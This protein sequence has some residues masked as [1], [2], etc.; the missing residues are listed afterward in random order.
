MEEMRRDKAVLFDVDDTLY[1]Q[2]VPFMESYDQYFG[3]NALISAETIYPVTRR[4]SDQMFSSAMAGKITMDELYIYRVRK[5][6]A[7]FG[8]GITDEEALAFQRLYEIRQ[9]YIRMSPLMEEILSWCSGKVRVGIITNGPSGRQ[10]EKVRSLG[11]ERWIPHEN[12]FVSEDVGAEKPDRKIFDYARRSMGLE[13]AES[14]FVGDAYPLDIEGALNA[15][16]NAVWFRRRNRWKPEPSERM[17]ISGEP[18][19]E[20]DGERKEKRFGAR[21]K[22]DTKMRKEN[23][24]ICVKTEEELMEAL[25]NYIG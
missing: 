8:V 23:R 20:K 13:S 24:M 25:I 19:M 4:Y 21:G 7:D 6:F 15:G 1:D 16:W 14:W 3:G 12:I 22:T 9:K 2:T 5:A 17:E 18:G 11:V 10:W